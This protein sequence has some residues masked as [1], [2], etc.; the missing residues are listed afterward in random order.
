MKC[1]IANKEYITMKGEFQNRERIFGVS[2]SLHG[3]FK[4]LEIFSWF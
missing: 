1:D 4:R 2:V 3:S